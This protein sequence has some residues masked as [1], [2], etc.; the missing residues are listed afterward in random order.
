MLLDELRRKRRQINDASRHFGA[1]RIC[2]FGSVARG[3]ERIGSDL[4]SIVKLPRAYDLFVQC[5]PCSN[6]SLRA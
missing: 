1:Q 6:G 5:C 2:V 3:E 4:G